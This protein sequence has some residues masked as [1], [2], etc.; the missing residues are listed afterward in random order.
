MPNIKFEFQRW[1]GQQLGTH[2][3][4]LEP[5]TGDAS[6][7]S[8]FRV[9]A[10]KASYILMVAPPTKE[11]TDIFVNLARAWKEKGLPVPAILGWEPDQGLVL[12]SDFG[13]VL[14][15]QV[16]NDETADPFYQTAM[17]HLLLLQTQIPITD[18]P[19]FSEAH[20]RLELSY[21]KEWFL[22][23]LLGIQIT[24]EINQLLEQVNDCLIT[25]LLSQPQVAIHRDYHS[26]NLMV[27]NT[28]GQLGIIDFQDAMVG[29]ITYDLVS[30]FKDCY[31]DWSQ[32]KVHRWAKWF[33]DKLIEN[34]SLL[35]MDFSSFL[36]WFDFAGLQRHLKVLGIFSRLKLRDNKPNYLADMPR[37]MNYVLPVTQHY[38]AFA[39]FDA[40]LRSEVMIPL[41]KIWQEQ[42][43][44]T[45][46]KVA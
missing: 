12:L 37:I 31:I 34:K 40:F 25:N 17:Q 23:K 8:Y 44:N 20:I 19:V 27:L 14:L 11:R 30:I 26:R 45:V 39:E 43:I 41:Q 16:L 29:P 13:D 33:F 36:G 3:L 28:Q 46:V 22:D 42:N 21:F 2:E 32:N 7:R 38:A 15:S 18:L 4:I 5:L 9:R 10:G 24:A 1:V 6:F 35:P